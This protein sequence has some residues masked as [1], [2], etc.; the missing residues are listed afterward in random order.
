MRL[1][2]GIVT[3]GDYD[4]EDALARIP[5]P[6]SLTGRRCLDVGTRDGFFA[7]EMERRAA[8]EVI[9]I[10]V[11]DPA[12]LDMPHPQPKLGDH[13]RA[14]LARR[15]AAYHVAHRALSSRVRRLDLSVYDLDR[16]Q[17]GEFA[18]AF[19]GTLLLHLRDPIG[20]LTA[21]RGVLRPDATLIS[22]EPVALTLTLAH[23]RQ[24]AARVEMV[25]PRPF[26]FVPN[27]A[28][29]ARM[30]E[31]AGFDVISHG[32]P[33]LMRYGPGWRRPPL[34][35]ALRRRGRLADWLT[36]AWGAPHTCVLA[37]RAA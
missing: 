10:D 19:I 37:R 18:F 22:N 5:F 12:R 14:G 35:S 1:P 20:A 31:A 7:F 3:P 24:P 15:D 17:V 21:V 30:L 8:D 13:V 28:A 16:A 4:L 23:P 32:R 33:Y 9:A 6:A 11:D 29:R 27:V 34:V 26:W 36:T 2:G 25:G